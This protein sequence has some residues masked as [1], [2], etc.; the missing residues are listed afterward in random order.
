MV[1][2]L[3]LAFRSYYEFDTVDMDAMREAEPAAQT[4]VDG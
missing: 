2:A 1:F 3:A 4:E